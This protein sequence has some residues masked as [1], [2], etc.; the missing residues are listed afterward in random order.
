[1]TRRTIMTRDIARI[2]GTV[3]SGLTVANMLDLVGLERRRRS[4]VLPALGAFG[5]GIAVGAGLGV[6]FAPRS[7]S[8]I[9][10]DIAR[11]I[12]TLADDMK[13]NAL[14]AEANALKPLRMQEP[15]SDGIAG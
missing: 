8:R 13:S 3:V 12:G 1:M 9:R 6:L 4:N 2:F 14:R 5:V 10:E 11:K 7:G 15:I